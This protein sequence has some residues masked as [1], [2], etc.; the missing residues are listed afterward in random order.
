VGGQQAAIEGAQR[1]IAQINQGTAPFEN[2]ARQ[3]SDAPTAAGGGES[4]WLVSGTI[5]PYLEEALEQMRPGQIS[6]PIQGPN[7]VYVLKLRDK[8]AGSG[9]TMVDLKQAAIRLPAEPTPEQLANAQAELTALRGKI[10][11]CAAVRERVRQGVGRARRPISGNSTRT[12]F[13]RNSAR[14]STGCRSARSA[15]RWRTK[16]G[17]HLIA[18]CSPPRRRRQPAEPAGGREPAA[19]VRNWEMISRPR[20]P[21]PAATRPASTPRWTPAALRRHAFVPSPFSLGD[22]AGIGP[23]IVVKGWAALRAAGPAF[24]V[25]GDHDALASA[26]PSTGPIRA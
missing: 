7:G 11:D 5:P 15:S 13:R 17:L 14:S 23:E 3:F 6:A 2:V 4:G 26:V 1:L 25:V 21:E 10:K 20:T 18:L 12:T 16:A 22:P 19:S 9:A 8:R 24:M